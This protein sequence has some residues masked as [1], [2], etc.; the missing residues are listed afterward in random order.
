ML[1]K[2]YSSVWLAWIALLG[3]CLTNCSQGQSDSYLLDVEQFEQK[4]KANPQAQLL[5]V[6]TPQEFATAHIANALNINYNG[7]D[8]AEKITYLDKNRPVFVYCLS[9]GRSRAAAGFLREQGFKEVYEMQGGIIRWQNA[10]KAIVKNEKEATKSGMS[11]AQ[12][13]ALTQSEKPILVDFSASWCAPCRKMKPFL[14]E[15]NQEFAGRA[16]IVVIDFDQNENL[17]KQLNV[18]NLPTLLLYQKAQ[19]L[20]QKEG[21][22]SKEELRKLLQKHVKN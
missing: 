13:E 14:D 5:D 20:W 6:R 7:S 11:L 9:G 22:T 17:A 10:N 2:K 12:F 21:F 1:R 15:L 8:F 18:E 19:K 16:S 4:L 3:G